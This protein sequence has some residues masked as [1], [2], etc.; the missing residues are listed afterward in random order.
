VQQKTWYSSRCAAAKIKLRQAIFEGQ[1]PHARRRLKHEYVRLVK[2]S[3]RSYV[4]QAGAHLLSLLCERSP[5][6]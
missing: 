4:S 3:K 5:D 2:R 6:A 1:C